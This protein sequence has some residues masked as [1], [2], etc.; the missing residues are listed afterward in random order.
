MQRQTA[1]CGVWGFFFLMLT[2]KGSV[3]V[4]RN[5]AEECT[6]K[7]LLVSFV[8][9]PDDGSTGSNVQN[10]RDQSSGEPLQS[11]S[12]SYLPEDIEESIVSPLRLWQGSL[13][14]DASVDIERPE[15]GLEISATYLNHHHGERRN[16]WKRTFSQRQVDWY[17]L[18]QMPQH[19]LHL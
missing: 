4:L 18:Q 16:N 15:G 14:L 1:F 2:S 13:S 10:A 9:C 17:R 19:M 6:M 8:A 12:L 7:H 11:F 3:A 5:R